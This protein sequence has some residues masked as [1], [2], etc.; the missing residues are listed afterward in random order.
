MHVLGTCID[1]D[2]P[3]PL[4]VPTPRRVGLLLIDVSRVAVVLEGDLELLPAE[5]E[6]IHLAPVDIQ[7]RQVGRWRRKS[8]VDDP[9]EEPALG[10]RLG[11]AGRQV[12]EAATDASAARVGPCA[13]QFT[14]S[15][16]HL[17]A[18]QFH[19]AGEGLVDDRECVPGPQRAGEIGE[20]AV[21]TEDRESEPLFSIV[22]E[23]HAVVHDDARARSLVGLVRHDEM[24]R[25]RGDC[26]Q[27]VQESCGGSGHERNRARDEPGR[28]N[29]R[30]R[31]GAAEWVHQDTP[32]WRQDLAA[33]ERGA[34]F[35][36]TERLN[37]VG[38]QK[39]TVQ[40]GDM[41]RHARNARHPERRAGP[42]RVICGQA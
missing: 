41:N 26:C 10:G 17:R 33:G 3:P 20:N 31:V 37:G 18:L 6:A 29:D 32:P 1:H 34:H 14:D 40:S 16:S 22:L 42:N 9:P 7:N 24:D 30:H 38:A 13:D 2:P 19:R 5:I 12:D 4:E 23:E 11:A 39:R 35:M 27:P 25:S 21:E 36:T 8:E 28:G 15:T